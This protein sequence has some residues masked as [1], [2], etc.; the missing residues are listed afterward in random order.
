MSVLTRGSCSSLIV[1]SHYGL[2]RIKLEFICLRDVDLIRLLRNV[3]TCSGTS[4]VLWLGRVAEKNLIVQLLGLGRPFW[5]RFSVVRFKNFFLF[6]RGFRKLIGFDRYF[7]GLR[8]NLLAFSRNFFTFLG[9]FLAFLRNFLALLRKYFIF[10]G[11]SLAFFKLSF[12]CPSYSLVFSLYFLLLS[13]KSWD[14]SREF[15]FIFCRKVIVF[16][17][18]FS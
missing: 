3:T 2:N 16:L 12:V 6:V 14:F 9:N 13:R 1:L 4:K 15:L 18:R 11:F 10:F 17:N 7:S 8:M 5:P